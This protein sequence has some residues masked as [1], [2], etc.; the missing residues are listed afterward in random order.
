MEFE[1]MEPSD[2]EKAMNGKMVV[3]WNE[4]D[5]EISIS[6]FGEPYSVRMSGGEAVQLG[7]I[8]LKVGREKREAARAEV[9][10]CAE[11]APGDQEPGA[12]GESL[13]DRDMLAVESLIITHCRFVERML[14]GELDEMK[15]QVIEQSFRALN[16]LSITLERL[17]RALEDQGRAG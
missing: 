13:L 11:N 10:L 1:K 17:K 7:E 6:A 2:E 16:H 3:S 4:E 8:L 15:A 14:Q 5:E 9:P 12:S